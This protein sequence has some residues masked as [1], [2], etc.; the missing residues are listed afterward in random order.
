MRRGE[1]GSAL[2]LAAALTL[3]LA[4]LAAL[5]VLAGALR[6]EGERVRGAA[7]LA[8]LAGARA[9]G[10]G[11]D[12]CAAVGESADRNEVE[13]IGC[14]VAGDEVEFVVSVEVRA[15]FTMGPATDW[16][17]ARAHAG[18]VTGAPE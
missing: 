15:P 2:P 5:L 1:R 11:A 13:V 6:A 8:A 9:Q 18:M 4:C 17:V 3:G 12:A 14:R 16:F 7:D 10:D